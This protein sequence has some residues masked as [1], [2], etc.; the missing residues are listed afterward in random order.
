MAIRPIEILIRARDEFSGALSGMQS[1]VLLAGAAIAGVFGISLFK[2]AVTSAAELEAQ[3]SDVQAVSGATKDEMQLLRKA[4]EE[5][6]A[7]T[8]FTATEAAQ[9]LGNLARSGMSAKDSIAALPATLNLAQAGS[10][11]LAEASS[12]MTRSLAGFGLAATDAGRVADLLAMAANASDTSVTGLGQALSYAAPTAS[13]MGISLESTLAIIGK[14]A[15]GGID[16]SRAGTA[17][18]AILAQ[19]G[20]PASSFRKELAAAGI[21]TGNFETALVQ[22]AGAGDKGKDAIRAVGTEAA[23]ALQSLLNRGVPALEALRQKLV[24]SAGSA[25]Q[26]AKQVGDNLTGATK[27]LS[28]SWDALKIA[29]GTPV[30]PILKDAVNELAGSLRNAVS[31]GTVGRFGDAIAKGF[32]AGLE[33]ARKFLA[34]VDFAAI[35]Q[36]LGNAAD[37]VGAAFDSIRSKAETA[38]DL[39]RLVW[40]AMSAGVNTVLA[41]V[42][43][44]GEAFA[45]VASNIQSGLALILDGLAKI[46]FGGVSAN[47]KAAADDMRL[48][49]E[50]TWASSEALAD[51]ARQSFIGLSDGAQ[52]A[53]DGFAGLTGEMQASQPAAT[54]AAQA[55][56][57]VAKE[58]QAVAE[59]NAEARRATEAKT[60]AD[61]SAKLAVAQ[62]RAEYEAAVNMGNWQLAAEKMEELSRATLQVGTD[63]KQT[64][65]EVEAAFTRMGIKTQ[66]S[67]QAAA[68]NSRKDFE[69]IKASGQAT[70]DGLQQAFKKMADAAIASGDAGAIAFVKSQAAAQGF[71]VTVD[72]AGNTIVRKMNEARDATRGAGN[73]AEDASK[74]YQG[75]GL[76]AEQAAANVKKLAEINAKYASPLGND[77]FASPLNNGPTAMGKAGAAVDNS[78]QFSLRDKLNNNTLS[79]ADVP[80]LKTALATIRANQ[81]VMNTISPGLN[82]LQGLASDREWANVATRFDDFIREAERPAP[83]AQTPAVQQRSPSGT[84]TP[85]A[86]F[87]SNITLPG[88]GTTR[89]SFADAGSQRDAEALLR[90]LTQARGASS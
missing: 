10:I 58:L 46:T 23:P 87:V 82:S 41:A 54:A 32:Q 48:S 1:K 25:D 52:M 28:S 49:A 30:L 47:F 70:A 62:L 11:D 3:L 56:G 17:L 19:F 90:Q 65:E 35:A 43:T 12:I 73:A 5:A 8:K 38:G 71:E 37:Q 85:G 53:R 4:A 81:A 31:D 14:F 61:E 15:D 75:L 42:F 50:A 39:V 89:L 59:K 7:S 13:A 20:D 60:A 78:L 80:L 55:I 68:E 26:F 18:N 36:R 22:L 88:A 44:V 69:T 64:T 63:A 40:G 83:A 24:E 21:T 27:T 34:E 79:D 67:L 16:A 86:T 33:W 2:G 72:K 29:L 9:A 66:A 57:T 6:G 74:S 76:S 51:K 77:K 84:N 45:G